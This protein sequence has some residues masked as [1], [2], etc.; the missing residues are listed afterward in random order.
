VREGLL[1]LDS[2]IARVFDNPRRIFGLPSQPDSWIEVDLTAPWTA[3]GTEMQ[4]RSRWTPF[5]GWPMR[6]RVT[7]VV[8]RG[9]DAF[10][11]GQVMAQ[12]GTGRDV[13]A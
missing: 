10:K 3:H 2:L 7:R 13:R 9:Q 6:G 1:T 5:E 4:T 11:D 12:P 8:L